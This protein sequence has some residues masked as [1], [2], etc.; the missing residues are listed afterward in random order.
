VILAGCGTG[1]LSMFACQAGAKRVI[2]V[3]RADIIKYARKIASA[4]G[5]GHKITFI[6]VHLK[7]FFPCCI[8]MCYA[9]ACVYVCALVHSQAKLEDIDPDLEVDVI[10]SEWMGYFLLF[11]SMLPS[12]LY[13]R[14]KWLFPKS[15]SPASTGTRACVCVCVC[16]C[17]G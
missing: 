5:L 9:H 12:V 10:V 4:N 8:S 2:A 7:V 15:D 17:L 3:D 11:E 14:D 6:Q 1:I 16:V 13:A